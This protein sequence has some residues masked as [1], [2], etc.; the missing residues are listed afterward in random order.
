MSGITTISSNGAF[1]LRTRKLKSEPQDGAKDQLKKGGPS[2]VCGTDI[3]D[4]D[5]RKE[6]NCI[7]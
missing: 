5:T 3:G 7:M 2:P 4:I 1:P 6:K